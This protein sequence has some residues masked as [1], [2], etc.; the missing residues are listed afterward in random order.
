MHY[1]TASTFLSS[2]HWQ[3][4]KR[5]CSCN[6][7]FHAFI[8]DHQTA[9]FTKMSAYWY[10][11]TSTRMQVFEW[12]WS[13]YNYYYYD[14]TNYSHCMHMAMSTGTI[15]LIVTTKT[16]ERCIRIHNSR[17]VTIMPFLC[18]DNNMPVISDDT[19]LVADGRF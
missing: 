19:L 5:L 12:K 6:F 13:T 8:S 17:S 16:S 11:C 2:H 1:T 14:L 15:T 3:G 9:S 7:K 4:G 18:K 10:L